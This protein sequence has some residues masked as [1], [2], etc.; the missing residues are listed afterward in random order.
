[1]PGVHIQRAMVFGMGLLGVK[2]GFLIRLNGK[3]VEAEQRMMSKEN[4]R[5]KLSSRA[6]MKEQRLRDMCL[7]KRR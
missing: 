3:K 4:V 2:N 7:H 1:M 5:V 6:V